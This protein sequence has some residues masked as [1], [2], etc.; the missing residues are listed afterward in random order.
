[1]KKMTNLKA[2]LLTMCAVGVLAAANQ[3]WAATEVANC[4]QVTAT[5]EA[6]TDSTPNNKASDAD[7][8]AAVTAKPTPTNEDDEACAILAVES[9]YDFGDAPKEYG[10][11][12]ADSGAQHEIIPGLKLGATV[13]E[14]ADGQNSS[15]ATGDGVDEDGVTIPTLMDGQAV[16]LEVK[17]TNTLGKDATVACWID[18]DK[19]GTFDS[20]EYGSGTVTAGSTDAT[21]NVNMPAVPANAS[22]AMPDG[23]FARCRLTTDAIDGT[24]A[25]GLLADGEVEDYKVTFTAQ[26]IFDLALVK[27][28]ADGQATTLKPG[29]AVKFTIEVSNQGTVDAKDVVVTDYIPTGLTLNDANWTDNADGTATL[30]T[31]I[32]SIPAGTSA[33]VD[34]IFKVADTATAGKLTNT[35]EIS[36]AKDKDGNPA[37]DKDSTPDA[38]KGNDAVV[39]DDVINEDGKNG[40]DEDDH[41]IAEITVAP[42]AKVD[43]NL[44]KAVT[45]DKGSP[46]TTA[47]RGQSVV[48]VLTVINDGPD[49]ATNVTVKDALPASLQYV[50]DDSAGKYDQASGIWTVG[51]MAVGAAGSKVLKITATLK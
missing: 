29:D 49:N 19:S 32:A 39:K 28:P 26:P 24:K 33:S 2:M 7:I 11:L 31:A 27:R 17:A 12:L 10:T 36:A 6:D 3:S 35:A 9:I 41:D 16:T 30:T 22:T 43:I 44:T 1:M 21:V 4:A 46:I 25:T 34:I 38:D 13:D 15:G 8:L 45:D 37:T 18:Y 20:T 50:S 48:Y 47:R 5:T 40:G 14:E 23:T 51:D 42:D